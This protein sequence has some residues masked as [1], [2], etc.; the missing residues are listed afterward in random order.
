MMISTLIVINNTILIFF[1]FS[2]I[3]YTVGVGGFD[4]GNFSQDADMIMRL[5]HYMRRNKQP[6]QLRF[7]PAATVWTTVPESLKE[8]TVQ[9]I[10]GSV[11]Y[12]KVS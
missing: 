7:N 2:A 6:Y 9:R 12:L 1:I 5:H 3:V 10:D 11:G 4:V 8:Y